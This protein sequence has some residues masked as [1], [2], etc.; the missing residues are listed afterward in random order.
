MPDWSARSAART[1]GVLAVFT[2]AVA[3]FGATLLAPSFSWT[4]SALSDLGVAGGLPAVLFNYG[5]VATGVLAVP[6]G[7]WY[8][9]AAR[10]VAGRIAGLVFVVAAVS[11]AGV[12]V[13]PSGTPLHFPAAVG[14]YLLG[15]Y[16][17][18]FDATDALLVGERRRAIRWF[19]VALG[20]FTLWIAWALLAVV[21]SLP[22]IAIPEAVGAA[23]IA[24]WVLA[25]VR[26]TRR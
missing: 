22:G 21:G 17:L 19:W 18:A 12:G 3:I 16:A 10:T 6:F 4:D 1:S 26:R 20:H 23:A 15:T 7:A 2:A 5:V 25:R 13:F 8:A 9:T 24:G 14:F 11:L